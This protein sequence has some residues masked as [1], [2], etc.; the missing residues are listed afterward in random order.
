MIIL[1]VRKNQGF[2]LS[3]KNAFLEKQKGRCRIDPLPPLPAV[4]GIVAGQQF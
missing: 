4:S 2:N 1:K 3:L